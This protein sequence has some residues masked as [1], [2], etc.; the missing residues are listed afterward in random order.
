MS[1]VHCNPPFIELCKELEFW[2]N[3]GSLVVL[4]PGSGGGGGE[5]VVSSVPA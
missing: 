2:S 3:V 1:Q 4:V 5:V